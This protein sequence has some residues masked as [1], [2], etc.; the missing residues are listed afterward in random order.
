LDIAELLVDLEGER[1]LLGGTISLMGLSS[2]TVELA[3]VFS[4][5]NGTLLRL[6]PKSEMC[7]EV[8]AELSKNKQIKFL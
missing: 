1:A 8:I 6:S 2:I 4:N 7:G 3:E 5:Y